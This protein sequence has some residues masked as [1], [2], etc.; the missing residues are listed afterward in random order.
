MLSMLLLLLPLMLLRAREGERERQHDRALAA[1]ASRLGLSSSCPRPRPDR[2][3]I[4]VRGVVE[5]VAPV[6]SHADSR[7]TGQSVGRLLRAQTPGAGGACA[8]QSARTPQHMVGRGAA[9]RVALAPGL[10]LLAGCLA[11]GAGGA[12]DD[13]ALREGARARYGVF[14]FPP[15]GMCFPDG[16]A[17]YAATALADGLFAHARVRREGI[18][19]RLRINGFEMA[20]VAWDA[21]S[22]LEADEGLA[23]HFSIPGLPDGEYEAE[24]AILLGGPDGE[25][26]GLSAETWFQ[27]DQAGRCLLNPEEAPRRGGAHER[28]MQGGGG[29]QRGP[30]GS[31][32]K[33]LANAALG[34][35]AWM[36]S[37]AAGGDAG[38]ACDGVTMVTARVQRNALSAP[39]SSRPAPVSSPGAAPSEPD[40]SYSGAGGEVGVEG[41][42]RAGAADTSSQE[43]WWEVDLENVHQVY[44][45]DVWA[46]KQASAEGAYP[47]IVPLPSRHTCA[48]KSDVK[49]P[50]RVCSAVYSAR[51]VRTRCKACCGCTPAALLSL[52]ALNRVKFSCPA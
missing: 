5:V 11:S 26:V 43:V 10:C 1:E 35:R 24:L 50:S 27:V 34:K 33:I 44:L 13:G 37:V 6:T 4:T 49:W 42:G 40:E 8:G 20:S 17:V 31:P 21:G 19:L 41:A 30:A 25:P 46:G 28:H 7:V 3:I 36:S 9:A 48:Q 45:V 39:P 15:P 23:H 38:H 52:H 47:P 2:H 12:D 32:Q 14:M 18:R 16:A 29:G 51:L 22:G